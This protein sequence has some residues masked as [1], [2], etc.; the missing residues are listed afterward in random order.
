VRARM[1]SGH[2]ATILTDDVHV[3]VCVCLQGSCTM[4]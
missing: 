3:C 1:A 4:T 2:H